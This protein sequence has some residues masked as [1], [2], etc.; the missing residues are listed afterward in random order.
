MNVKPLN[1]KIILGIIYLA[2]IS[3]GMYFLFTNIDVKDLMSYEFIRSNKDIILKYKIENFMFLSAIF[4]I[5]SIFWVLLLGFAMPLVIFSGF[6]F[7][8]WWGILIILT[9]TTIGATLLYIL[10]I[11]FFKDMIEEKLA[12]KFSQLRKFFI[13]NDIIYFMTYR[14]AG[15]FGTPFPIQNI[16]PA[17][18][19]MPIKNY[20]IATVIGN[21]PSMFVTVALGSGIE[22]I[23]N[24]NEKLSIMN[25][26]SSPEIYIPIICFFF[27][28][29]ITLIIKKFYFKK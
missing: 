16:L 21:T 18:F 23:M 28:L 13:K 1:L 12:P 27:I 26:I 25:V 19:N 11:F 8:K 24:K 2:I 17:L 20:I 14:F 5:F 15:G 6:I 10:V 7:G 4:F 22:S 9:A 29:I 3:M